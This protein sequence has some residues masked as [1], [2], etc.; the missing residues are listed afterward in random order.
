MGTFSTDV[1]KQANTADIK[2]QASQEILVAGST[3]VLPA[4]EAWAKEYNKINP[5]TK[6][7]VQAGGSGTGISSVG[8][9][10]V[11]IGASSRPLKDA[12]KLSYPDLKEYQVGGSAVVFIVGSGAP[13]GVTGL[14]TADAAAAFPGTNVAP[15]YIGG[16]AGLPVGSKSYQ[17]SDASGTEATVAKEL[18]GI[19][20]ENF[21]ANTF[22]EGVSG[23]TGMITKI[24]GTTDSI[25]FVDF[26][27][28]N[29]VSTVR[30]LSL[31][32]IAP[33]KDTIKASLKDTFKGTTTATAYPK[34]MARGLFYFT[35]GEPSSVVKNYITYCQS[36]EGGE[37]IEKADIQ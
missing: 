35:N 2:N 21:D 10:I 6:I 11:D 37:R 30:M 18:L 5:S 25:G 22:I 13:V 1:S 16:L 32:T 14:T 7:S 19:A 17:R 15:T 28:A 33:T 26:G 36:P 12:E 9:G 27:Y 24:A 8:M 20:S 34:A 31:N 4:S 23:N 3:T 29:G